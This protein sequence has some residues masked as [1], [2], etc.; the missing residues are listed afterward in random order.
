MSFSRLLSDQH[1]LKDPSTTTTLRTLSPIISLLL[2]SVSRKLCSKRRRLPPPVVALAVT[3]VSCREARHQHL[4]LPL[5]S[6][7][8]LLLLPLT[9]LLSSIIR[10]PYG[11]EEPHRRGGQSWWHDREVSNS[12]ALLPTPHPPS[13]YLALRTLN[14]ISSLLPPILSC[15]SLSRIKRA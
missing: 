13:L 6:T 15:A 3:Q 8:N 10:K 14:S 9:A 4:I 5:P 2:S 7:L 1:H 11:R 12:N